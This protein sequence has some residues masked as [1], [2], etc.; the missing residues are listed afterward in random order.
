MNNVGASLLSTLAREVHIERIYHWAPFWEP[1]INDELQETTELKDVKILGLSKWRMIWALGKSNFQGKKSVIISD[2]VFALCV[3][4]HPRFIIAHGG[5]IEDL[6]VTPGMK[7]RAKLLSLLKMPVWLL[8]F[9]H[10]SYILYDQPSGVKGKNRFFS[11]LRKRYDEFSYP[12]SRS[13]IQKPVKL[14]TNQKTIIVTVISRHIWDE[15]YQSSV[16]RKGTKEIC[17]QL[18][19]FSQSEAKGYQVE[20]R[21]LKSGLS[22]KRSADYLG[23]NFVQTKEKKLIWKNKVSK[24][25]FINLLDETDIV[26]DQF[27]SNLLGLGAAEALLRGCHVIGAFDWDNLFFGKSSKSQPCN[28]HNVPVGKLHTELHKICA[29]FNPQLRKTYA[30]DFCFNYV[31]NYFSFSAKSLYRHCK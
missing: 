10:A 28:L 12:V 31:E 8:H 9:I 13:Y 15:D 1:K 18:S 11:F 17:E 30:N 4:R 19:L 14:N 16:K 6:G 25:A 29:N 26:I 23:N 24:N 21:M 3:F 27:S 7:G 5:D 22:W 20:I 2:K